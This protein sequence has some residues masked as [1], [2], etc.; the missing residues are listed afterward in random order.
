MQSP[1]SQ[2]PGEL[3]EFSPAPSARRHAL[4]RGGGHRLELELGRLHD[5]LHQPQLGKELLL[6]QQV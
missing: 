2:V 5:L 1:P 6:C 3:H 4:R